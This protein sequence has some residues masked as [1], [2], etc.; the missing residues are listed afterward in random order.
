M[1]QVTK[2]CRPELSTKFCK[3]YQL[4]PQDTETFS[5][6]PQMLPRSPPRITFV[7]PRNVIHKQSSSLCQTGPLGACY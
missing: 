7:T 3:C 6:V 5:D 1:F 2:E 4:V